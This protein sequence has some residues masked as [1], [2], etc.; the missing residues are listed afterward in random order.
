VTEPRR[1][2]PRS[3]RPIETEEIRG[4]GAD[5]GPGILLI[6]VAL[7]ILLAVLA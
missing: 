4:P 7:F 3:E 1:D 6:G 2:L 5:F